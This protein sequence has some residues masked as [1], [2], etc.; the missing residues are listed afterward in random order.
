MENSVQKVG[1]ISNSALNCDYPKKYKRKKN[2]RRE[3]EISIL[4][5]LHFTSFAMSNS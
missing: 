2:L 5:S 1:K 3:I 4:T